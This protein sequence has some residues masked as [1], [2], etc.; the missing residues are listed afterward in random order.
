MGKKG[1][2]RRGEKNRVKSISLMRG[3]RYVPRHENIGNQDKQLFERIF[4]PFV[5]FAITNSKRE[6]AKSRAFAS[7]L[8]R[9]LLFLFF[10][11]FGNCNRSGV[12]VEI[13]L[14]KYVSICLFPGFGLVVGN[15]KFEISNSSDW[16]LEN[17]I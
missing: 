17:G 6:G 5:S 13:V 8:S 12:S 4:L 2:K 10:F 7:S 3:T 1:W 16:S 11:V 15:L 14:I 9:P